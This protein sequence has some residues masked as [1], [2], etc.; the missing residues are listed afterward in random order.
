MAKEIKIECAFDKTGTYA[1][2]VS[3][4]K[5]V[6]GRNVKVIP[7]SLFISYINLTDV[8]FEDGS[9]LTTIEQS[10]FA[11][12]N[13]KELN[14]PS[15]LKTIRKEAFANSA[16]TTIRFG[17]NS[18]LVSIEKDAFFN[19][20]NLKT[21]AFPKKKIKIYGFTFDFSHWLPFESLL[22]YLKTG[23]LNKGL[24][25]E[26]IEYKAK[27]KRKT[28]A[29]SKRIKGIPNNTGTTPKEAKGRHYKWY[30]GK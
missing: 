27:K 22:Y 26:S 9:I 19:C 12:T 17:K 15:S 20:N 13:I 11:Y 24:K 2:D 8:T 4:T 23:F 10:G 6:V 3:I 30:P 28:I 14:L 7:D 25:Q 29:L 5:V 18:K 21:I 1:D 16:I